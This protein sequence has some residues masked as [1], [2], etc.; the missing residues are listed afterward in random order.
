VHPKGAVRAGYSC[1][2]P[3]SKEWSNSNW[4]FTTDCWI[5]TL[6]THLYIAGV[7][8]SSVSLF[9]PSESSALTQVK[10]QE[11]VQG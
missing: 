6:Q 2:Y 9:I 5:F 4:T 3:R 8:Y 7:S 1:N 11:K 10:Q